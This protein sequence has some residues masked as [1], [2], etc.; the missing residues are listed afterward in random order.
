MEIKLKNSTFN[1]IESKWGRVDLLC[2]LECGK[3]QTR[4]FVSILYIYTYIDIY[5]VVFSTDFCSCKKHFDCMWKWN[6]CLNEKFVSESFYFSQSLAQSFIRAHGHQLDRREIKISTRWI[7]DQCQLWPSPTNQVEN[8]EE[9]KLRARALMKFILCRA[10]N[11][12]K[13]GLWL[14]VWHVYVKVALL[15]LHSHAWKR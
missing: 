10:Y 9:K 4:F 15:C 13:A 1:R 3:K 2:K 12:Q 5:I 7:L 8:K 6:R 11:L 14:T